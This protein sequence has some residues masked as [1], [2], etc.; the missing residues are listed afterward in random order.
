ML[1]ILKLNCIALPR[2]F[3]TTSS[4]V[5][6]R[7]F[8]K[9]WGQLSPHGNN[10]RHS[11]QG[12]HHLCSPAQSWQGRIQDL[13]KWGPKIF[14]SIFANKVQWSH[15]DEVGPNWPGS[16]GFFIAKYAFSPFWVPFYIIF[17]II[18]YKSFLINTPE[19]PFL[20]LCIIKQIFDQNVHV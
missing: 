8:T 15:A 7:E 17:E 16:L 3:T 9:L 19:K 6:P 4:Q 20:Y 11:N 1:G 10:I 14:L 12:W 5:S 13:V 2:A 18:K